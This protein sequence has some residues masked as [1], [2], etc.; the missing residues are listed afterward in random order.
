MVFKVLGVVEKLFLLFFKNM[1]I[2]LGEEYGEYG[3][4]K[5]GEYGLNEKLFLNV[6]MLK[7]LLLLKF[8]MMVLLICFFNLMVFFFLNLFLF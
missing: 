5:F 7:L 4:G 8:F 2:V 1:D 6:V 3:L